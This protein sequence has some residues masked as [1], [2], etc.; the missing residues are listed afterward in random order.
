MPEGALSQTPAENE[1]EGEKLM[2]YPKSKSEKLDMELFKNPTCEYRAAPFWAWNCDMTAELLKKEIEYMKDMGFGGFHMHPRVGLATPYLSDDFMKLVS[3]CVEKAKD[4]KML[5]WL[6][7]ED[8][9]PSGFAGGLNTKDIEKRQKYLFI[10]NVPYKDASLVSAEDAAMATDKLPKSKYYLAACYDIRF[11][12]DIRMI[13][14][15]KISVGDKAEGMKLFAYVEYDAPSSWYNGQAYVDT[16]SKS[17]IEDFV[18]ITHERYKEKIGDEFGK[19]VPA[20]FTDEPQMK[21]K[22]FLSHAKDKGGIIVPFT[23]DLDETFSA[24][25]GFSMF[26]RLPELMYEL[27]DGKISEM[28]YYYHDHVAERFVDAFADTIGDWC[29]KNGIK[30]MG[31]LMMEPALWTQTAA[32]GET[33]RS[34]RSL[35][36]PGIDMLADH[37]ELSTAKQC[38]SAARQY[39]REGMMSE[40]YGVTNWYFDFKGHKQQGDWQAAFGVT[41]RV[42]HLFWVSMRGESKRDYPASIGYQ[43]PWYKEY[44]YIEDHFARVNT[45]MTRGKPVVNVGVIHPVESFWLCFG[46]LEQTALQRNELQRKF[47]EIINWLVFGSQDFDL[48]SESLLVDQF[49]GTNGGFTVGEEK[50]GVIVVPNLTTIRST[51]LDALEQF[52]NNGGKVIFMGNIPAYVDAKPSD[53]AKKLAEK[54]R[55]VDWNKKEL[56]E[57]IEDEREVLLANVN[58]EFADN[59]VYNMRE[60]GDV[61][62]LF[63]SHVTEPKDY[64]VSP[65]ETYEITVRGE[66]ALTILDTLTGKTVP[67]ASRYENGKTKFRWVCG[68]CD[69]LLLEMARGKREEGFSFIEKSYSSVEYLDE[70]ADYS[71]EEPNVLLLDFPSYSINGGELVP[72]TYVLDADNDIR[73]KLGIRLR[74]AGMMQPWACPPDKNPKERVT[75]YF[76][77]NSDISYTGALLGLESIEYSQVYLNGEKADMAPVGYYI[78]EDAIKTVKL[79]EIKKG[80]NELKIELR[81]GDITQLEAYYLLGD[82]GVYAVGRNIKLVEKPEK[83][84]FDDVVKQS[85]PFYG[86]NITYSFDYTGEGEKTLEIRRFSGAAISVRVDGER[87]HGMLAFPPNRLYLGKL[88]KGVHRIDITLYGDRMNTLGQLHNTILKPSYTAPNMWRPK[89]R[90]YTPEYML[91]PHGIFTTPAIL[92]E[93]EK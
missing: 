73:E 50:Y 22:T 13:S 70:C 86:G 63:V 20:I 80:K 71:L 76:E 17:A 66:W 74:T 46:P 39:G 60:D 8:K 4:E 53:R 28:R 29:E 49:G 37:H 77:I 85:L 78:D 11:D 36:I 67:L 35:T 81:F 5:A 21:I 12:D 7:D 59:L 27:A 38:Q 25:Y 47:Y 87:V 3:E 83:L 30:S 56:F 15:K 41:V 14:Y 32:S 93:E 9:W 10:T 24:K 23:T 42:P 33:M 51:T 6:Y 52:V 57:Y 45:V 90:F 61:R 40:L 1:T 88:E 48:I 16:M 43:S 64:D 54:C 19:T 68:R 82:F 2:L 79:P 91:R 89:G 75:L 65:I 34:Y 26:D 55:A 62:H 69:S 44:K 58:G 72:P 92:D 18:K 31:H 84:Y